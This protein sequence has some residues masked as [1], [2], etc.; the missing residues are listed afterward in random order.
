M[1]KSAR[2]Q[3]IIDRAYNR[4][5]EIDG[6]LFRSCVEEAESIVLN[7]PEVCM[8]PEAKRLNIAARIE[9]SLVFIALQAKGKQ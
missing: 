1:N 2:Q 3:L 9:R 7:T 5:R 6:E 4:L 8:L